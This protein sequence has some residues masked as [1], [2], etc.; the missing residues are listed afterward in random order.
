M[1]RTLLPTLTVKNELVRSGLVMLLRCIDCFAQDHVNST[2]T[3]HQRN[4][5]RGRNVYLKQRSA[6]L[7][8]QKRVT[9]D[10]VGKRI[11]ANVR[12][13]VDGYLKD[14]TDIELKRLVTLAGG[15]VVCVKQRL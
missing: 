3:G 7:N 15:E 8:E 6:K 11:L 9:Q 10:Q 1:N 4:E 12:V 2:S 5:T 14:T 13:Y